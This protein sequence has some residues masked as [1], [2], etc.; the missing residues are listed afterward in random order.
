MS[1]WD[2]IQGDMF[3]F[4]EYYSRMAELLPDGC[5]VVE[6]GVANGKSAIFLA[7]KLHDLGKDFVMFMV[8]NLAYG[9]SDQLNTII[10]SIVR[11]GLGEKIEVMAMSSLDAATK[12][13]D[14]Y[15]DFV[16]LDSSHQYFPTR[17]E[18]LIWYH[19][20]KENAYLSGHDYYLYHEVHD[21]VIELLPQK[22]VFTDE[23]GYFDSLE[24]FKTEKEYGVWQ[25]RKTWQAPLNLK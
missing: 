16:F 2:S 3:D 24:I 21:A 10:K 9:G 19:K 6:C 18:I 14:N 5:R 12:F 11:S 13:N 15:F 23:K 17:A 8:D 22:R 7:E 1:T 20:I 4:E 25:Y